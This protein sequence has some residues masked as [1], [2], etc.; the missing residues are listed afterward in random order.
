MELSEKRYKEIRKWIFS[1]LPV[2]ELEDGKLVFRDRTGAI[3]Y[4]TDEVKEVL[5]SLEKKEMSELFDLYMERN[6]K[7]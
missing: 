2:R 5:N 1:K 4:S 6:R 3:P 7:L